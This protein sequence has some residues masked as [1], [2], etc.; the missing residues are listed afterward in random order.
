MEDQAHTE[1]LSLQDQM[2]HPV[3]FLAKMCGDV[4]YIAQAICQSDGQKF[5]ESIV[6]EVNGLVDN[7]N[8]RLI[9]RKEVPDGKPIQQSVWA[10]R[11]KCNFTTGAVIKYKAC[12]NLHGGMQEYGVNYYD[13]HAP[14]VTWFAIRLMIVFGILFN[15]ALRQINFVMA[16]PQAP[17]EMDMYMEQ[18]QGIQTEHGKSRDHVLKLLCKIYGQKASQPSL[19]PPPNYQIVGGRIYPIKN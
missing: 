13:I 12:L 6:K 10:M 1:H 9:K 5:V 19:E 16:Y 14:V 8:W 17:I 2:H 3:A 7:Q 18:P 4:M 11:R 15:Q